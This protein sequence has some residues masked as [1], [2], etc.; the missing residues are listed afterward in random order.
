MR[1]DD[2]VMNELL[3]HEAEVTRLR[4]AEEALALADADAQ[5]TQD[6]YDKAKLRLDHIE[7]RISEGI[8]RFLPGASPNPLRAWLGRRTKALEARAALQQAEHDLNDALADGA[9]LRRRLAEA[10]VAASVSI[11]PAATLENLHGVAR[12]V[13]D[14]QAA[15][16]V[17]RDAVQERRREQASRERQLR[18]AAKQLGDWQSAWAAACQNPAGAGAGRCSAAP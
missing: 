7:Q 10:L 17:Q 14:R 9:E 18:V 15:L 12:T 1:Q 13:L 3:R 2:I 11:E 5:H 6:E 4:Q 8:R 16:Q